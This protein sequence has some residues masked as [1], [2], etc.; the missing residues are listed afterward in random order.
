MT[1]EFSIQQT[2][3]L[4]SQ[5]ASCE[6]W[7][8]AV[9]TYLPDA[10]WEVPHLGVKF[11]GHDA[12][13]GALLQFFSRM[14]YVLQINTPAVIAVDGTRATAQSGIRECGK[15]RGREE[16]FEFLGLYADK[17]VRTGEGWKFAERVFML[18][19]QHCFP[20]R[21]MPPWS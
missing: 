19:G 14:E 13:R 18:R 1:E 9:G 3:S 4:Y 6:R 20:L 16:A 15:F 10:V 8:Q 7:D 2:L 12:I 21:P 5:A 11:A 17:L